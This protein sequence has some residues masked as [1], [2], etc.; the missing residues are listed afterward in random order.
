MDISQKENYMNKFSDERLGKRAVISDALASS[1]H[2][3][4]SDEAAYRFLA[5]EKVEETKLIATSMEV[6]I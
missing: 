3:M 5:N 2:E 1:I 4:S 6:A